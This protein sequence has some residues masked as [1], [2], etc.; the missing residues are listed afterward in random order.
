VSH[1]GADLTGMREAV[2]SL[3]AVSERGKAKGVS[4]E[5]TY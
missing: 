3:L 5:Q 4:R 2:V 1:D